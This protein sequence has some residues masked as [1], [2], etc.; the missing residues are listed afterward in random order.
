MYHYR[1]TRFRETGR[2]LPVSLVE[3][4]RLDGRFVTRPPIGGLLDLES[5]RKVHMALQSLRSIRR[6]D[7]KRRNAIAVRLRFSKSFASRRHRPNQPRLRSTT[8][9]F[10]RTSKPLVVS[11]RFT[12]STDRPGIAWA[13]AVANTDPLITAIGEKLR[14]ERETSKQRVQ[15]QTATVAILDVGRMYDR[16][17]HQAQ[18]VDQDMSL[19]AF[20]LLARIVSRR[21]DRGPPFSALFTL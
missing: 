7:A 6:M 20:D 19:L 17:Q 14:Q 16:V 8:H 5:V 21:I 12:I 18:R 13:A 1:F 2:R 4:H 11:E 15:H 3:T 9:R 10:G